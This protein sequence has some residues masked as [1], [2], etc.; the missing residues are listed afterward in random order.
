MRKIG[1]IIALFVAFLFFLAPKTYAVC[2]EGTQIPGG[3]HNNCGSKPLVCVGSGMT[4]TTYCCD[5]GDTCPIDSR[6]QGVPQ[7]YEICDSVK[8]SGERESCRS[9][10]GEGKGAWTA[11]DASP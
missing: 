7:T 1:L 11:V 2:V 8:D 4:F 3:N 10:M 5:A 6:P 9:C